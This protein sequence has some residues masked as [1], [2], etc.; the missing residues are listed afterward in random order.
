MIER[1]L[2]RRALFGA[3]ML[4][5]LGLVAAAPALPNAEEIEAAAEDFAQLLS[6]PIRQKPLVAREGYSIYPG[7]IEDKAGSFLSYPEGPIYWAKRAYKNISV[8]RYITDDI[9]AHMNTCYA[10]ERREHFGETLKFAYE[11]AETHLR[12]IPQ[13][14]VHPR[15]LNNF[16]IEIVHTAEVSMLL[17][18]AGSFQEIEGQN[19]VRSYHWGGPRGFANT[20]YDIFFAGEN[21]Q[22]PESVRAHH[23]AL[24]ALISFENL[25]A[26]A[27]RLAPLRGLRLLAP[28]FGRKDIE[29]QTVAISY[30]IGWAYELASSFEGRGFLSP[31]IEGD[32]KANLFGARVGVEQWKGAREGLRYSAL[33]EEIDDPK[34]KK[35]ETSPR[36]PD[37]LL[38]DEIRKQ[39]I[40]A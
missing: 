7:F 33:C 28:L 16:E 23:L 15:T 29:D 37:N 6:R 19:D 25:Y 9:S 39:P 32:L 10:Q 13:E 3:S 2:N 22:P 12:G 8:V 27:Y 36:V 4:G 38:V 31:D 11:R 26:E 30:F 14:Q 34:Y 24:T 5:A 1:R 40:A 35:L 17:A 18:H 21:E 20:T